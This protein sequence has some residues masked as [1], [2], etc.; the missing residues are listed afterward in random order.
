MSDHPYPEIAR[1]DDQPI[2]IATQD[3]AISAVIALA[4]EGRPFR[5]FTLNLDHL[6]KRRE[7]EAFRAAYASATLVSADGAPVAFLARRQNPRIRRT[8]GADMVLPLAREAART[9]VPIALF[10]SSADVLARAA[11]QL[12][13]TAPGLRIAHV[14]APPFGFEPRSR[15]ADEAMRRIAESGARIVFV[16]LGAPKQELLSAH[17]TTLGLPLGFVCIGAALDFLAG[18]QKRAPRAM[19][20]LGL[21][22]LWRLGSNPARFATRYAKCVGMLARLAGGG[23][24]RP[25]RS[26]RA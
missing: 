23:D 19:Q 2:N 15:A 17:A 10:G 9:G 18:A 11:E 21:E 5:F 25:T 7:D 13:A 14:E 8:T 16:A 4:R 1:I 22:W 20:A 26:M 12:C 3:E 6:V 24:T